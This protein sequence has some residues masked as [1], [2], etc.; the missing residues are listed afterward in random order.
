MPTIFI[1]TGDYVG[2]IEAWLLSFGLQINKIAHLPERG[3][4]V[5]ID[6]KNKYDLDFAMNIIDYKIIGE[7]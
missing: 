6:F 4:V 5:E 3:E 2:D 1:E 7:P